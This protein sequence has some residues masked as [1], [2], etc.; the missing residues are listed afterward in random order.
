MYCI[1]YSSGNFLFPCIV[2]VLLQVRIVLKFSILKLVKQLPVHG[3]GIEIRLPRGDLYQE[4]LAE[5]TQN[6]ATVRLACWY[7]H[8][9]MARWF[10]SAA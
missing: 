9:A 6:T 8:T 5:A 4:P 7:K 3:N 2:E 10:V 1:H